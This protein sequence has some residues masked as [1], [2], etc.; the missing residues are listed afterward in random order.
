MSKTNETS[1][2]KVRPLED[3]LSE[4]ELNTVLGGR[5]A[6]GGQQEFLVVTMKEATVSRQ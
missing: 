5:K 6:G 2:T 1:K 3:E 4:A